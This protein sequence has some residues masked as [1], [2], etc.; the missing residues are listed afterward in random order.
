MANISAERAA[1]YRQEIESSNQS[2]VKIPFF[3]LPNGSTKVRV[4][5]AIDPKNPEKDFYCKATTHYSVSPNLPKVPVTCPKSKNAKAQC[6]VCEKVEEL[7]ASPSKSDNA[8]ASRMVGRTRYYINVVPREGDSQG[9][10]MVYPAPKQIHIKLLQLLGDTEYPDIT[11]PIEGLDIKFLRTGEGKET[12]YDA[13]P[14]PKSTPLSHDE[15]TLVELLDNRFDLSKFRDAPSKEEIEAF[16]EG[17]I[18][19]FTT[20]G[21]GN[22][23]KKADPVASDDDDDEPAPPPTAK[24]KAAAPADDD[25]DD[26]PTPPAKKKPPVEE[27]EEAPKPR[28][29][30]YDD[31]KKKLRKA[32]GDDD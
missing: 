23:E 7:K 5:P 25:S 28:K 13:V 29:T 30:N 18:Q 12:K 32:E 4:L 16:M 1:R 11:D 19:R 27:E 26:A 17:T 14:S 8:E 6:P 31:I 9:K 20:G 21:F 22:P 15:D 24:K 10:V 2:F 3:K